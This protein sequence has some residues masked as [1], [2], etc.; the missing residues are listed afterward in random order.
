M[1][2]LN[3]VQLIGRLGGD[4]EVKYTQGGTAVARFSVATSER[5]TDKQSGEKQEKTEWHRIV[6]W[7]KLA[8]ICGEYLKKGALVYLEGRNETSKYTDKQ[9]IERY[10]TDVVCSVMN[11]L[12]SKS[13]GQGAPSGG[14]DTNNGG[15]QQQQRPPQGQQQGQG[16]QQ[17]GFDDDDIPF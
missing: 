14:R 16:R 6:I 4:P 1:S 7:G 8:E 15:R 11:M 3:K 9:G 17:Q 12:G 2:S 13:D 10:A 5:W